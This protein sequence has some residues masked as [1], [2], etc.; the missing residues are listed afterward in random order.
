M[1]ILLKL[2]GQIQH[3]FNVLL[4][5]HLLVVQKSDFPHMFFNAFLAEQRFEGLC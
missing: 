1:S 2:L 5:L 4:L 3:E